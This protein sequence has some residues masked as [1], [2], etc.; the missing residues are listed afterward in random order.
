MWHRRDR[1]RGIGEER[2][3]GIGGDRGVTQEREEKRIKARKLSHALCIM[4]LS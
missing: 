4:I 2:G 3:C 1:G